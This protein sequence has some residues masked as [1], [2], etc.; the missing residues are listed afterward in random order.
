M[1]QKKHCGNLI[2]GLIISIYKRF[3]GL[4]QLINF[5]AVC[6]PPFY[7]EEN[8]AGS[9]TDNIFLVASFLDPS[10]KLRWVDS[11]C[12][13]L[14]PD[15]KNELK[16]KVQN[17]VMEMIKDFPHI[18]QQTQPVEGAFYGNDSQPAKKPRR[19]LQ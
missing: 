17:I 13:F 12:P 3:N 14:N 2:A 10:I 7:P 8:D 5:S 1:G 16:Q 11:D 6:G 19:L 4:L 9:W 15:Q 18:S